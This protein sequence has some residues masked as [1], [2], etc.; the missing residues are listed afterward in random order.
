VSNADLDEPGIAKIAKL[1]ESMIG[2]GYWQN[3][4]LSR[5]Q[6]YRS[7]QVTNEEAVTERLRGI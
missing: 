5:S 4:L 6:T 1:W 3:S 2:M 7:R